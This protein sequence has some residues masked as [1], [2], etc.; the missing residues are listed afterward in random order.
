MGN[1]MGDDM[2]DDM[3]E[4][5]EAIMSSTSQQSCTTWAVIRGALIHPRE[6]E[7]KEQVIAHIDTLYKSGMPF[8]TKR[9]IRAFSD[10]LKTQITPGDTIITKDLSGARIKWRV[11]LGKSIDLVFGE[12]Q[13]NKKK[14]V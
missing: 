14:C 3:D 11:K 6:T 2:G 8:F 1:D 9:A 7:T 12:D 4:D 5:Y 13:E 10:Q